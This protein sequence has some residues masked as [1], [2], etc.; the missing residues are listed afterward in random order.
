MHSAEL[1]PP[2]L[3]LWSGYSIKCSPIKKGCGLHY[4]HAESFDKLPLLVNLI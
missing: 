2:W 3:F 1:Q 4:V